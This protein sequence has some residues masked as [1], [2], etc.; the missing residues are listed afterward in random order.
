MSASDPLVLINGSP[1]ASVSPLDRSLAFGDGVFRTLRMVAG[2]PVW[3]PDHLAKLENDCRRLGLAAPGRA[4]WEQDLAWLGVRR[5]DAVLKLM[6]TRGPGPR[7]YRLPDMPFPTRIAIATRLPDFPDPVAETGARLRVCDLRLGHQPRLAGIKHL[8]RLENVL[9]RMEWDDP[10]ID[11]GLLLDTE[12]SVISG[13]MSNLFVRHG[14]VWQ[15][16]AIDQCGVAGVTRGRLLRRLDAKEAKIGLDAVLTADTVMLSNSLIRLRWVRSL[17][18]RRW[19]RPPD[20]AA[21]L[22]KLCSED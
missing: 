21:I 8:N 15:T 16:P 13:V 17:G 14:G 7:G 10:A 19:P 1:E 9:A 3:W 11:E 2:Q 18:E 5:P 20:F 12:G 4:D 22:E 6:V